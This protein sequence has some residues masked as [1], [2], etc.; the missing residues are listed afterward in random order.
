MKKLKEKNLDDSKQ[1]SKILQTK[2]KEK[3]KA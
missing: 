1:K 3:E 2:K